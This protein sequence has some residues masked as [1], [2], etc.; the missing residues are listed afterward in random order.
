MEISKMLTVSTAHITKETADFIDNACK[1]CISSALIVYK[2]SV[3]V[4]TK[5]SCLMQKTVV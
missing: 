3:N 1:D 2:K 5:N 4:N